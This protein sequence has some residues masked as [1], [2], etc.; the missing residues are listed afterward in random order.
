MVQRFEKL[1]RYRTG[2][3]VASSQDSRTRSRRIDISEPTSPSSQ[4][5]S[6]FFEG[7]SLAFRNYG[8]YS[9][10]H[11]HE[12]SPESQLVNPSLLL[13]DGSIVAASAATVFHDGVSAVPVTT[14]LERQDGSSS[15]TPLLEPEPATSQPLSLR[16]S[17]P[18]LRALEE[19]LSRRSNSII[20]HVHSVLRYSSTSSWASALSWRSSWLSF[21]SSM[22]TPASIRPTSLTDEGTAPS[23]PLDASISKSVLSKLFFRRTTHPPLRVLKESPGSLP[24]AE[25][26]V[27]RELIDDNQLPL[28]SGRPFFHLMSL[29]TRNCYQHHCYKAAV[30]LYRFTEQEICKYCGFLP[31]HSFVTMPQKPD[32]LECWTHQLNKGDYFNNRP[33]H[34]AAAALIP[35]GEIIRIIAEGGNPKSTNTSGATFVHTL[36][37]HVQPRNLLHCYQPLLKYLAALNFDFSCRDYHGQTPWHMLL[38]NKSIRDENE[39]EKLGEAIELLKPDLDLVDNFGF[40]IRF[41][42]L[43][44]TNK[45]ITRTQ[46]NTLLP[47]IETPQRKFVDFRHL[48]N[49]A[50]DNWQTYVEEI[51]D[52]NQVCWIDINGD[53]ALTALVKG[54]KQ[55]FDEL[56]LEDAIRD[57]VAKGAEVNMRDRVGNTALAIATRRGLRPAVTTLVDLGASIHSRD[58]QR[59]GILNQAQNSL[60]QAKD[61]EADNLYSMILSCIVFLADLGATIDT[62]A[63]REWG[64]SWVPLQDLDNACSLY[65]KIRPSPSN[66]AEEALKAVGI[67]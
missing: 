20:R 29:N 32:V 13:L 42:I 14:A 27:W 12:D 65:P 31:V 44:K 35:S 60:V 49:E 16:S 50:S 4:H 5:S 37:E 48:L 18:S 67:L 38:E 23:T 19:R 47:A 45:D 64:A 53:T 57:M 17:I 63:Y 24:L 51:L 46:I 39:L 15:S 26:R 2:K 43:K 58:Y 59:I 55:D 36:F 22:E 41:H 28:W 62:H 54:W 52:R 1:R 61:I 56:L 11:V 6:I 40:S 8:G 34:F 10:T 33:L 7:P 25:Q 3:L 66:R 9:H 21:N 30:Y